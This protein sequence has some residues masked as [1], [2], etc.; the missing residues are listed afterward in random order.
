[1]NNSIR[2][3][4]TRCR[5]AGGV[6]PQTETPSV[7]VPFFYLGLLS[8]VN[9]TCVCLKVSLVRG[10]ENYAE[11]ERLSRHHHCL[12]RKIERGAEILERDIV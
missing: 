4:R 12:V 5:I 9:P 1:M 3:D 2:P 6:K 11:S 7:V 10:T 8:I